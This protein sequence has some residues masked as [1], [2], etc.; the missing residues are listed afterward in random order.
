M[1]NIISHF[2]IFSFQMVFVNTI[3][4]KFGIG[5]VRLVGHY[6]FCEKLNQKVKKKKEIFKVIFKY[7]PTNFVI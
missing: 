6:Y 1:V 2:D 3:I 4:F 5:S 7:I